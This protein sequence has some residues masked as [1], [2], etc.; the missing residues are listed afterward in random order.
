[1]AR[2][3]GSESNTIQ[4][5]DLSSIGFNPP[6]FVGETKWAQRSVFRPSLFIGPIVWDK[7]VCG[8]RC[9]YCASIDL[10]ETLGE[11]CLTNGS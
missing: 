4:A 9:R 2:R 10:Y 11:I 3:I 6:A 1:M 8:I 5:Q 7:S